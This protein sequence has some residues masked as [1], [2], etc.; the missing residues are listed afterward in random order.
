MKLVIREYLASLK[1]REELD[2]ILPDLLSELG[3]NVISR[4]VRGA[5]QYGVDVAAIGDHE[6]EQKLWLFSVKRGDLTRSEWDGGVQALRQS[7]DEIQE[8]YIPTRVPPAC[9]SLPVVI[10][11]CLG[12]EIQQQ[13]RGHVTAYERKCE[14]DRVRFEEWNGDK[15]A[16][17]LLSGVL[18]ED[19]LPKPMRASFQKSV[20][21]LDEPEVAYRHFADLVRQLHA[22]AQSDGRARVRASRQIYIALW[23]LYVWARDIGNVEAAYLASELAIL[24]TWDLT[25]TEIG[26][27]TRT[28][29]DLSQ[30]VTQLI[31]LHMGIADD[32]LDKRVL[33][34]AGGTDA[35]TMA[36][37]G[38]GIDANLK[39]FDLLGRVALFG[40]WHVWAANRAQG[41]EQ[42][43][44]QASAKI[45]FE[46]A[47]SLIQTNRTLA[48]PV[49][50]HQATAVSLVLTLWVMTEG[51][52]SGIA[53][54]L[55]E[56]SRRLDF[57]VRVRARYPIVSHDYRDIIERSGRNDDEA[58]RENTAGSTLIPL[59]ACWMAAMEEAEGHAELSGL[60]RDELEHCTLQM[61]LVDEASE[62]HLY[63]NSGM[64]GI[65]LC[66][67]TVDD[68][69]M[70]Q[71]VVAR[72]CKEKSGFNK[73][74][75]VAVGAWP[76]LMMA[77]R[78]WRLPVPPDA[79]IG[80]LRENDTETDAEAA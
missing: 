21:L 78:H 19:V 55:T 77:C 3:F 16:E 70:L 13:V 15:L 56:M 44:H 46:R 9:A 33:A 40:M 26:S 38:T 53:D 51:E 48:L 8:L 49:V 28:I 80:F 58:F 14:S 22:S 29:S 67:L 35:V 66:D 34:R 18:K 62:D 37:R 36:V 2:A 24:A 76:I 43:R 59:L 79:W 52:R 10:C 65:A 72:A 11:I 75:A 68:G 71:K 7:L 63:L 39:L 23:I 1:E 50:D 60:V 31:Q 45:A 54:W 20:A 57:T 12:G 64:H 25:K 17:L 4:P 6:G 47:V 32:L 30:V 61:W 27:G 5:S 42:A 73:L 41:D 74:S 69:T